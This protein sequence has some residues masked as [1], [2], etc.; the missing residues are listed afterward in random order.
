MKGNVTCSAHEFQFAV[1][2]QEDFSC[3]ASKLTLMTFCRLTDF[4]FPLDRVI[5]TSV[6][7]FNVCPSKTRFCFVCSAYRPSFVK[8]RQPTVYQIGS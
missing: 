2:H 6:S 5:F 8:R 7:W 4:N 3:H 1:T